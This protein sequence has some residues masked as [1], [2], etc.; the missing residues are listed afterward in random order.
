MKQIQ[1]LALSLMALGWTSC[2]SNDNE[3][4]EQ[5]KVVLTTPEQQKEKLEK[6]TTDLVNKVHANDFKNVQDV[7]ED[8]DNANT[9]TV[10]TWWDAIV[11][12][13]PK[14]TRVARFAGTPEYQNYTALY[15]ASNFVGHFRLVDKKWVKENGTFNDLQ[16]SFADRNGKPCVAR[17]TTSGKETAVKD[18]YLNSEKSPVYL[19]DYDAATDTY[20]KR[21]LESGR[22]YENTWMLPENVAL[23]LT[24]GGTTIMDVK[25]NTQLSSGQLTST[26]NVVVKANV[27][28]NNYEVDVKRAWADVAKG[29]S[30]DVKVM[31]NGETLLTAHAEVEGFYNAEKEDGKLG[32]ASAVCDILGEIQLRLST[33]DLQTYGEKLG[34]VESSK[35]YSKEE[36]DALIAQANREMSTTLH[37][38]NK[39]EA[40]AKV[41]MKAVLDYEYRWTDEN[42]KLHVTRYWGYE[43]VIE[44]A[45]KT[46]YAFEDYFTASRFNA[47]VNLVNDLVRDFENEFNK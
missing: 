33:G 34:E 16:F 39:S 22:R 1:I 4:K 41:Y 23:T 31:I 20:T 38:D 14:L 42:G 28:I 5:P 43:P 11:D 8:L 30:A 15:R 12:E 19:W 40:S 32:K 6:V 47:V 36:V 10:E 29:A 17:L 37:Y 21:L 13:I 45:D 24:Q 18:K 25:V 35:N 27:K 9:E 26:T 46:T 7:L 2:S 44:F 3:E